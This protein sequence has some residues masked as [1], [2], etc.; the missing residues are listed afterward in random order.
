VLARGSDLPGIPDGLR[1]VLAQEA[2]S[3]EPPMACGRLRHGA[4]AGCF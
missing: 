2:T 3:R 4:L 1:P